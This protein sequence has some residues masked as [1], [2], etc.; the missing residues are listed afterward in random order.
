MNQNRGATLRIVVSFGDLEGEESWGLTGCVGK[1]EEHCV[2][3]D[4]NDI[5]D[6]G[7][8]EKFPCGH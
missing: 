2:A 3:V 7:E 8:F 5:Y 6:A 4:D 1:A